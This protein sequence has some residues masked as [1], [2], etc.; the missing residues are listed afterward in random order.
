[1]LISGEEGKE[2]VKEIMIENY[3]KLMSDITP[4]LERKLGAPS[5]TIQKHKKKKLVPG[6]SYSNC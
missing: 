6:I 1:M 3:P 5:R 2:I 4:L